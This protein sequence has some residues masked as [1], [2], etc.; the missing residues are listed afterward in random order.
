MMTH[1]RG[2][3]RLDEACFF[4]LG[5][6]LL[7]SDD[8]CLGNALTLTVRLGANELEMPCCE[9]D[10]RSIDV[11]AKLIV[12]RQKL[13]Y[14]FSDRAPE[15]DGEQEDSHSPTTVAPSQRLAA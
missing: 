9:L 15:D 14:I 13:Q 8:E 2:S 4:A 7:S 12:C 3:N 11:L 6:F 1:V 5:C 10:A